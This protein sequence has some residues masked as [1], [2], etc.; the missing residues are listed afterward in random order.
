MEML[1]L[2]QGDHIRN[3]LATTR[4][5]DPTPTFLIDEVVIH[6]SLEGANNRTKEEAI[7]LHWADYVTCC[8][9]GAYLSIG[10]LCIILCPNHAGFCKHNTITINLTLHCDYDYYDFVQVVIW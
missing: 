8:Y 7:V 2:T 1:L 6:Y 4:A 3:L 10:S 9:E 5:F